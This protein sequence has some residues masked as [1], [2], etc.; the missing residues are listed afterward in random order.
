[1]TVGDVIPMW[2]AGALLSAFFFFVSLVQWNQAA[3]DCGVARWLRFAVS[4]A[5]G[6]MGWGFLL[7]SLLASL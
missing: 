1:M 5:T 2:L 7:A 4:V 3:N 6:I